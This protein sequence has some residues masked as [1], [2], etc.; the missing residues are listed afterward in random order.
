MAALGACREPPAV[1]GAQAGTRAPAVPADGGKNAGEHAPLRVSAKSPLG[2]PLHPEPGSS[3]VSGRLADGSEVRLLGTSEDGR[4]YQVRAQNGDSG[5]ITRRYVESEKTGEAPATPRPS[6]SAPGL[7][8]KE[9]SPWASAQSCSRA[10]SDRKRS[11]RAPGWVRIATWNLKWFPDGGPGRRPSS[12]PEEV[13][14]ID[15]LA[16][17]IAWLDVDLVV[18]QEIKLHADARSKMAELTTELDRR[19]GGRWQA[20]LDRCPIEAGQH[21]GFL[22]D[23]KRVSAQKWTTY[24]SFNPHGQ[25]CKDQLRPGFGAYFRFPGGFDT[26]LIAAHLKSG[27]ERRSLALREKSLQGVAAVVAEARALVADDDVVVAGDLNTM[28]CPE[29]SPPVTAID[30]LLRMEKLL[31]PGSPILRRVAADGACSEYFQG[32]GVLLD[33]FLVTP[34]MSELPPENRAKISGFCAEIGCRAIASQ[35]MPRAHQKLSD[36][37]PLVL[38]LRDQDLD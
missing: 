1:P 36:H 10:L 11:A 14:D 2:V 29:C 31:A 3:R 35:R 23:G 7:E 18:L 17:A 25:P 5:W 24:A 4:W 16:C 22:F 32:R 33:H 9:E 21:V 34:S 28:G 37:C 13:S 12:N 30:E 15:W 8:L 26:H 20:E 19:T 27:G 38:D 6:A